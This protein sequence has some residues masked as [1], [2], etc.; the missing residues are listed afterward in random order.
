[1]RKIALIVSLFAISLSLSGQENDAY[2]S[3]GN[4]VPCQTATLAG[5]N[6]SCFGLSDGK[7]ILTINQAG[8]YNIIWSNGHQHLGVTTLKDTIYNLLAGYYDVQVINTVNGC[9]AFDIVNITQPALLTATHTSTDVK[10]FGENKGSVDLTVTGG[11][12]LYSYLWSNGATTADLNNVAANV[13]MVTVTDGRSCKAYDTVTITQPAQAMDRTLDKTDPTCFGFS[14]GNTD[15]TVWGGTPPYVYL[16]NTGAGSQDLTNIPA[17]NYSVLITDANACSANAAIMLVNPPLLSLSSSKAN[18]LCFGDL[19]GSINLTVSGGTL[20]YNYSWANSDYLLSW[21]I[22]DLSGLTNDT[23]YVT[24]TDAK[25]CSRSDSAVITSPAMLTDAI[26]STDVTTNGGSNGTINLTSA[27]GVLPHS[28]LWSNNSTAQ[29]L[30][31]LTAGIYTVTITDFN[32]CKLVDTVVISEPAS[33]LTAHV[34]MTHVTCFGGHDGTMTVEA[35]GGTPPYQYLWSVGDTNTRIENLSAGTYSVIVIDQFFDSDTVS[36]TIL[37]PEEISISQIVTNVSCSGLPDGSID[38][39]VTGGTPSYTYEWYNSEYVLAAL[40]E[41]VSGLPADQYYLEVTDTLGCIAGVTIPIS[42]PGIMTIAMNSTDIAC[43]GGATGTA[44][45]TVTGGTLPYVYA[46]S[47][48]ASTPQI[49]GLSEGVYT[50]T[51]TDGHSCFVTDSVR[52]SQSDSIHV[53]FSMQPVS[54]KDQH[55]GK[56]AVY[57]A[58][59]NGGY[60]YFWINDATTA[61]IE[62]LDAGIYA[63]TVTDIM[64]CTGGGSVTVTKVEIDCINIPTCFTPNGDGL[65]DVWVIKDAGLYPAFYME[66]FNRWGQSVYRREGSYEDWDGTYEGKVLPAETYYYFIRLDAQSEMMQGTITI[67]R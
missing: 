7:A 62:N 23:Y 27:G 37:Q 29:N 50:V 60:T 31:G 58:G 46:W 57:A 2:P 25:G 8:T 40:T 14:N 55:D 61:A 65:N 3:E 45:C 24:V 56:A 36:G 51:V 30:T 13:Y 12:P 15:L 44:G 63:V 35:T 26:T 53:S 52:I 1:M 6:V 39:T 47:N 42:Q 28:Y 10:C 48:G 17:G 43:A 54:C 66:V 4:R 67:V 32:G 19:S 33:P 18:N 41:D 22:E 59:G 49:S 34:S 20:P 38:V 9:S 5:T 16:W 64:G 21:N 11:T